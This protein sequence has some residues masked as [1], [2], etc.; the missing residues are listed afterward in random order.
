[1][2]LGEDGRTRKALEGVGWVGVTGGDRE[3]VQME[4][5]VKSS[6]R[7]CGVRDARL[8]RRAQLR[9]AVSKRQ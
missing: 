3:S 6:V 7:L 4:I 5:E 9:Q 1:M 8:E 2:K